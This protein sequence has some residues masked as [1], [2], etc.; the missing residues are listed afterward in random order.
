[1]AKIE[2]L[3]PRGN[4]YNWKFSTVGGVTRVNIETGEDIAHLNELDQKLWTVLSCPVKGLEF[5][6]KTLTL[7]DADK[8][9]R[10]RVNEVVTAS[11]W[12]TKVLKDMN[13]LLEG[14]DT[15]DFSQVQDNTDEGKEVLESARLILKQLGV[16]KESI[17]MADVAE[18]LAGYEEKC[19]ADYTA[20]NPDPH[21]PPYGD[22]SD[23]AEAAVNALRAKVADFFMRCKL[24]QFDEE[25]S[26][27]L[28]VQVEKIAAISG[29]N[30]ADNAA[31]ISSYPLARPVKDAKLPLKGGIN[32]AWQGAFATLKSL[33]LDVE[34]VGKES[35][36][37]E[38]W[39]TVLAKVD[40]YTEWKA[41]GETA[42]NEAVAEML[43]IHGAA[44]EPVE[45][46]LRLCRDF[47][48]LLHNFVVFKDFYRRDDNLQAVFQAGK[49]YVDQRCC[50]LCV[51]V[52]DMPKHMASA[53][54]SGLFL[55]YC[56]CVS[57]VQGKEMDIVAALTDGDIKDL[58]EGKNA[59]FYD[60]TGQDW[61]A[62][63]TKI[64]DN[65][66]SIRQAFWSPYRKFG[67][68]V[69]D[70]ITKNAEEKE[71]KQFDEMTAKADTATI[72]L[73]KKEEAAADATAKAVEKKAQM[74]DIA[75][76][77]G[78]F[79]AIGLAIGAIGGALAA[80][81]GFVTAK[82]YN[83]IL[84]VAAVVIFISGPSML[85]A[86]LKLRKRNLGPLLNA[87]GWAINSMVKINTTFGQTLTSVAKYPKIVGKDPFAD[88]KMAWWKKCLIW[89]VI[90]AALFVVGFKLT[91]HYWPWECKP[92]EEP[93]ATEVTDSIAAPAEEAAPVEAEAE[94]AVETP[95]E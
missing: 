24:V 85:L 65:P 64:V 79:A 87:N 42:M 3:I 66:I 77:A 30:L 93:A 37:E 68:W 58:H 74:F 56:H 40:A 18:Y 25:A 12:L 31:E 78:I 32:P 45:K 47:F 75:K 14:K 13:Y 39:N 83:I 59:I 43:K 89:L 88:K 9:G 71:S 10:I 90:L 5:D 95:A 33:V 38:E 60:R 81:G 61:D 8:D 76:F 15:I 29:S 50:E 28:D 54:K 63:I 44:I 23:D 19:K 67:K 6:E 52:S 36:T 55:L 41:A 21:E 17:S 48:R 62:T 34:F 73:T 16:E 46:L 22:K 92:V 72:N 51:K 26:A 53:G 82:W 49:L 70:K 94:T 20:A 27:A 69:T 86:W 84:L 11:Q 57:K 2:K 91:Q 4:G 7:M 35:I 1:M 80:L